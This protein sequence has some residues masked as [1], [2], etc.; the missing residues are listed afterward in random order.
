MS[1]TRLYLIY[2]FGKVATQT[3]ER[4]IRIS[5]PTALVERYHYLLPERLAS[6]EEYCRRFGDQLPLTA[7]LNQ[8]RNAK[9]AFGLLEAHDPQN[10]WILTGFR[11][12]LDFDVAAF[13]QNLSQFVPSYISPAPDEEYDLERLDREVD[14]V[15]AA[16]E[17]R[18]EKLLALAAG[19]PPN[20]PLYERD[21]ANNF[22]EWFE[23]EFRPVVGLDVYG[24]DVGSRPFVHFE[25]ARGHGLL[26]RLEALAQSLPA[27][28]DELPLPKP[29]RLENVNVATTKDYAVL[30]KRFR[31]RFIP[32]AEM[33]RHFYSGRYYRHFYSDRGPQAA[34]LPAGMPETGQNCPAVP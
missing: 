2:A 7:L 17:A 4:S 20:D 21:A 12:P 27:L 26:Y 9:R 1:P 23:K 10:V 19:E 32:S 29:H 13:F 30:Y 22:D 15:L 18:F 6:F 28:L 8:T 33:R 25:S 16:Y 31:E 5:D 14:R 3:L 24:L 34:N 11:D